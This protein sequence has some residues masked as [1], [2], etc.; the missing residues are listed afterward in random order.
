MHAAALPTD[1]R[2]AAS[3]GRR[4]VVA[5]APY[6]LTDCASR[7]V[8]ALVR[9]VVK[10]DSSSSSSSDSSDV[11]D[12]MKDGSDDAII[13]DSS[14]SSLGGGVSSSKAIAVTVCRAGAILPS[15]TEVSVPICSQDQHGVVAVV[16][17]LFE[18][19]ELPAAT[20]T[21]GGGG[22]NKSGGSNGDGG[23]FLGRFVAYG[24]K[25][26]PA[27][28][29][30]SSSSSSL[31]PPGSSADSASL[32]LRFAL[33][34]GDGV[35]TVQAAAL[36]WSTP[37]RV[38]KKA[39][40]ANAASTNSSTNSSDNQ[41]N[42]SDRGASTNS[43]RSEDQADKTTPMNDAN[44]EGAESAVPPPPPPPPSPLPRKSS[45]VLQVSS[46]GPTAA[47]PSSSSSS[48]PASSQSPSTPPL[49]PGVANALAA[50]SVPPPPEFACPLLA[51]A[52]LDAAVAQEQASRR[53]DA[54]A[55]SAA[56]AVNE[57]EAS[58]SVARQELEDFE[59]EN[60]S[61]ESGSGSGSSSS[62]DGSESADVWNKL[63]AESVAL[64]ADNNKD[65][66]LE[67]EAKPPPSLAF[68]LGVNGRAALQ[69]AVEDA[70]N[71]LET[72]PLERLST[73]GL[74][75][76]LEVVS[77]ARQ[78]A[79]TLATVLA[80]ATTIQSAALEW[81]AEQAALWKA[82]RE[83]EAALGDPPPAVRGSSS[84]SGSE[85]DCGNSNG[86]GLLGRGSVSGLFGTKGSGGQPRRQKTESSTAASARQAAAE[87]RE[88]LKSSPLKMH[89]LQAQSSLSRRPGEKALNRSEALVAAAC[90]VVGN[91]QQK[92]ANLEVWSTQLRTSSQAAEGAATLGAQARAAAADVQRS[93]AGLFGSAHKEAGGSDK[94]S[95][96]K[97]SDN[98]NR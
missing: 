33:C 74:A 67:L 23:G 88:W 7:P 61:S 93:A 16:V 12:S 95:S 84:S 39:P 56:K 91:A 3:A 73:H 44:T 69:H 65:A 57:L 97:T 15:A 96:A 64:C 81:R 79:S 92:R 26:Q 18:D 38:E 46:I 19:T 11:I 42:S 20:G 47:A 9:F 51:G 60:D 6:Q 13:G 78:H 37:N 58:V 82:L 70:S 59:F 2:R 94:T 85:N 43:S 24:P 21:P 49:P 52:A 25:P 29:S 45:M 98:T 72:S 62:S 90:A 83:L 55:V 22:S 30:S 36:E 53:A 80:P 4:R 40:A 54:A 17:D 8:R 34:A 28:S 14:N 63:A 89:P 31:I 48:S 50:P 68:C 27:P 76:S 10:S 32:R 87:V 41:S 75:A 86:S 66:G 71:F 35:A 5:V 77:Q 1:A